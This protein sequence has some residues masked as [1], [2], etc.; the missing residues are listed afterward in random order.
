MMVRE[1]GEEK[2]VAETY[3][4]RVHKQVSLFESLK[5]LYTQLIVGIQH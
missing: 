3:Y 1:N 2:E 5:F 4:R